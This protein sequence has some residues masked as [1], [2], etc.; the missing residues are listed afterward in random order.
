MTPGADCWLLAGVRPLPGVEGELSFLVF[1][2]AMSPL[3]RTVTVR[4]REAGL[5][6]VRK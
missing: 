1:W 4:L 5:R 6:P 2:T 3:W